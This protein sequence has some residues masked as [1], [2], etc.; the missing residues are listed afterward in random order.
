MQTKPDGDDGNDDKTGQQIKYL[1]NG[2]K[3]NI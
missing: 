3:K 2:V 1:L